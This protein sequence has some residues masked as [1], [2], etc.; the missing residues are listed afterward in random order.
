MA[1]VRFG[2]RPTPPEVRAILPKLH[3]Y[4]SLGAPPTSFDISAAGGSYPMDLNDQL[5][6]CLCAAAAHMEQVFSDQVDGR[7]YVSSDAS[8]LAMYQGLG[9]VPGDPS[10]D[11]GGTIPQALEL[12]RAQGVGGR[13]IR[14]WAELAA[15]TNVND[16]KAACAE[17]SGLYC[18]LNVP[19]SALDQFNA[20]QGW[21]VE[22]FDG[23]IQGGH[24][25]PVLGYDVAGVILVT[26]ARVIRASWNFFYTYFDEVAVVI[27][28][29]YDRLPAGRSID[30]DTEAQLIA[31]LDAIG[32]NIT[33]G[34]AP[35]PGPP[36]PPA[37]APP[38]P[39]LPGWL[40]SLEDVPED[41][42]AWLQQ[43]L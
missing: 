14:G 5:G 8:V 42:W 7:P 33:P 40:D 21:D 10:T 19:Q 32:G 4:V 28:T 26:W 12:W 2:R 25:V 27:P 36:R 13:T 18:G 22:P 9:Y 39:S 1:E 15:I 41:I 29:D 17:F 38:P 24:C 37:P 3:S 31:D 11:N 34:P 30:D 6:D 20:G 35:S 23:G 16:V 43:H